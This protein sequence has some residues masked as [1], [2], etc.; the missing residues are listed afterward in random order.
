MKEVEEEGGPIGRPAFSTN[1]DLWELGKT[2][3][4]TSQY[5]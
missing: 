5:T 2:E 4:P 1:M 3:P